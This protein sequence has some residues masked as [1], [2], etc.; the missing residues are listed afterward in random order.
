MKTFNFLTICLLVFCFGVNA[1]ELKPETN[2]TVST[3]NKV[4][5]NGQLINYRATTGTQPLW[6]ENGK[7][8]AFLHSTY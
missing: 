3:E 1:Q 7:E 4:T 6:D 2:K 5:I 8:I